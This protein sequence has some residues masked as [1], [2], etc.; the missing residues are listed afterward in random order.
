MSEYMFGYGRGRVTK[1][2]RE[3]AEAIAKKHGA[4]FCGNPAIPGTGYCYWFATR[5]YGEPFNRQTENAVLAELK[6][7]KLFPLGS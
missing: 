5:N 7:A 4:Y 2:R 6:A 3:Q 1:A